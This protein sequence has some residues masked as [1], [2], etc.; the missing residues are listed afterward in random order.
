MSKVAAHADTVRHHLA[1]ALARVEQLAGIAAA[2]A[3]EA[4]ADDAPRVAEV[5]AE[6]RTA[7]LGALIEL[8]GGRS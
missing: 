2:L 1:G 7:I 4:G 6:A 3:H 8:D 5:A